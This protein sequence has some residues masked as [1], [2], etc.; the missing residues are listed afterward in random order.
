M[1]RTSAA[2]A[3]SAV[4]AA[5]ALFA[6]HASAGN[7]AWNVSVG[8]PGFA[9]SAGQPAY[10]GGGYRVGFGYPAAYGWHRHYYRPVVPAQIVYAPPVAVS[11]PYY[12][13]PRRVY[14]PAPV[15]VRPVPYGY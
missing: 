5:T 14:A 4:F 11:V 12:V 8:G 9:V 15:V 7:V 6:P 2:I 1:T 3:V 13:A 10:W